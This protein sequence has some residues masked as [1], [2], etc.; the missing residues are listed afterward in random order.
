MKR[1][2]GLSRESHRG[3]SL[4]KTIGG[5]S[6]SEHSV[7]KLLQGSNGHI[8]STSSSWREEAVARSPKDSEDDDYETDL[9][10]RTVD[11]SDDETDSRGDIP[12]SNL[13]RTLATSNG[14]S[15]LTA[16]QLSLQ[17]QQ[18]IREQR[19]LT[20]SDE[21]ENGSP[22]TR[23]SIRGFNSSSDSPAKKARKGPQGSSAPTNIFNE[24][25]T[26]RKRKTKIYGSQTTRKTKQA[27]N[28]P[29]LNIESSQEAAFNAHEGTSF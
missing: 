19:V 28:V 25:N 21:A 3:G 16:R 27:R 7:S 2:V 1:R 18:P 11:S 8:H 24:L 26:Q 9:P 14:S 20:T 6:S 5:R 22:P 12:P 10:R 4:L 13:S 23:R 29:S 15:Q 17:S